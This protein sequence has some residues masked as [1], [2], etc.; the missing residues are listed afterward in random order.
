MGKSKNLASYRYHYIVCTFLALLYVTS[1]RLPIVFLDE[2]YWLTRIFYAFISI[3]IVTY[4]LWLFQTLGMRYIAVF[5]ISVALIFGAF[6]LFR[7][8]LPFEADCTQNAPTRRV[9]FM[10]FVGRDSMAY[11]NWQEVTYFY[12][13][14][15]A[16]V[17]VWYRS[18]MLE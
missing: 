14:Q 12:T 4:G 11:A 10:N 2:W 7:F 13:I 17:G 3:M 6:N 1:L 9:C 5:I 15:D 16:P 18:R 8:S